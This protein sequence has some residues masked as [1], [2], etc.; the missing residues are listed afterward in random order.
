MQ[1]TPIKPNFN[2]PVKPQP[3][4]IKPQPVKPQQTGVNVK[5]VNKVQ[6][7]QNTAQQQQ[8]IVPQTEAVKTKPTK[9]NV[10]Q[11]SNFSILKI[12]I[13][14][15]LIVSILTVGFIMKDSI[16]GLFQKESHADP[17]LEARILWDEYY[18]MFDCAPKQFIDT[19]TEISHYA[20]QDAF[21]YL[22]N[23]YGRDG[24][25]N[26]LYANRNNVQYSNIGNIIH[27]L[28]KS[29][30]STKEEEKIREKITSKLNPLLGIGEEVDE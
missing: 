25:T 2:N 1:Q 23:K 14:V 19:Y 24:Y 20:L 16:I 28:P 12:I 11:K 15:V 4:I 30:D 6:P 10:K 13:P 9:V 17:K 22:Q 29:I 21:S 27:T 8:K 5:S 3:N 7:Q 18:W 26:E